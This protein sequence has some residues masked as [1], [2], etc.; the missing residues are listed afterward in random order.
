LFR[1]NKTVVPSHPTFLL[2]RLN[3]K[4]KSLH[5]D[6]IEV[7]E[8]ESLSVIDTLTERDF[9]DVFKKMA[10]TLGTVHTRGRGILLR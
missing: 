2:T 1:N 3:V 4:L 8:A 5:F 7:I 6:T 9:Q 10:E